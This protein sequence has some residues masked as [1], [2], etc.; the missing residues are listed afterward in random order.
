VNKINVLVATSNKLK[1]NLAGV[2]TG[3][4]WPDVTSLPPV[5]LRCFI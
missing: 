3:G 2:V 5:L 1:I 4:L